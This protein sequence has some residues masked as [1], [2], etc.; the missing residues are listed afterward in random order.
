[1]AAAENDPTIL[2]KWGRVT[3]QQWLR[4]RYLEELNEWLSDEKLHYIFTR[5]PFRDECN[6]EIIDYRFREELIRDPYSAAWQLRQEE[7]AYYADLQIRYQQQHQD[8]Q[9]LARQGKD[10]VKRKRRSNARAR[11]QLPEQQT[12]F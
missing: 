6:R 7:A 12:I 5:T 10:Y 4:L 11:I 2:T 9:K 1:M 3:G 8:Q